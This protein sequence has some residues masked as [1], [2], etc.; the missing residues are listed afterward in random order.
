M[1]VLKKEQDTIEKR[2]RKLLDLYEDDAITKDEYMARSAQHK[3]RLDAM[4]EEREALN[5]SSEKSR[6]MLEQ[7]DELKQSVSRMAKE[8]TPS[9]ETIDSLADKIVVRGDS[10][11]KEINLEINLKVIAVTRTFQILRNRKQEDVS[12]I[13]CNQRIFT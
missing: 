2:R 6:Q 5:A 3:A 4:Q 9:K 11:K 8:S 10:T 12:C 1:A 13:C 7:L